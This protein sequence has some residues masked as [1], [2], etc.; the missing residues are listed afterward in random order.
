MYGRQLLT[1]GNWA[2][3]AGDESLTQTEEPPPPSLVQ[4][5]A[6]HTRPVLRQGAERGFD[7]WPTYK[8]LPCVHSIP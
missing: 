6:P 2:R 7:Y 1:L 3:R 5:L 4:P 8:T